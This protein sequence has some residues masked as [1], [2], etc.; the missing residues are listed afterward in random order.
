MI[1]LSRAAASL[2]ASS[3]GRAIVVRIAITRCGEGDE[4]GGGDAGGG[5]LAISMAAGAVAMERMIQRCVLMIGGF[6]W[7]EPDVSVT[8]AGSV[9]VESKVVQY[10]EFAGR[11]QSSGSLARPVCDSVVLSAR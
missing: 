1:K 8:G 6:C 7:G 5:A 2:L 11:T 4:G 3:S 10:P 9:C